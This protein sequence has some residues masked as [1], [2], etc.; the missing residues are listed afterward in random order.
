MSMTL[1]IS[2][3]DP[4]SATALPH[5]IVAVESKAIVP[6]FAMRVPRNVLPAP[7]VAPEPTSQVT[8]PVNGLPAVPAFS[9][10]TSEALAVV[11]LVGIRKFQ[12][13]ALLPA[14]LRKRVPLKG[15]DEVNE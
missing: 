6:V 7:S 2:V 11:S 10:T 8:P 13:A 1:P 5:P 4:V 3:T 9:I 14:A 12:V 15:T